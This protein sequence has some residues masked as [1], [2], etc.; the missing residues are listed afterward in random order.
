MDDISDAGGV[1]ARIGFKYQ[2]HVAASFVLDMLDDRRVVQVECE[3]SDDITRVL[4][5]DD[6]EIVEYIQVKTTDR[7]KK[8][9]S[10][11]LTARVTKDNPTSLVEKSLLADRHQPSAR[12]RIV[13]RRSVNA[14]LAALLDPIER[15]ETTGQISVLAAKLKAKYPKTF[16][17]NGH[18]L[19]YWAQNA[20]WDVRSG[21]EHI[22]SQNLQLLNRIAE[23]FG[24]NPTYSQAKK[25][26]SDL[27]LLVEAAAAATRRNKIKKVV[28]RTMI[29]DWWS[30][31]LAEVRATA[32]ASAKPYRIR[33]T[34]FFIEVH[35]V[36]YPLEKRQALGY[37]AQYERKV[38]RSL[39]LS[40]YLVSWLAELSLKASE[41]AEIDQLNLKQKLDAGLATIR[42]QRTLNSRELLGEALLHAILRHYFGSEPVACKLFHRSRLGDRITRNAHI[43]S[44]Q[45]GDQLW[46]GR[47]YFLEGDGERELLARIA[48]DLC[49]SLATE[50]LQEERQV[51]IQL[52]EPQHLT[53]RSLW[54]A[55]GPG[56]PIDRILEML[57]IPV[58]IAYDSAVLGV[59]H[60]DDYQQKLKSEIA[61]F[62]DRFVSSLPAQTVEVQVHVI[63]VPVENLCLLVSQFEKEIGLA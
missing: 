41:L 9:T 5:Q 47:T 23:E 31:R 63:F 48:D 19:A 10:T 3:T 29:V 22:E 27:L 8:W 20:L 61:K 24:A 34:S 33:G 56:A 62:G 4:H 40:Q 15:R 58:L 38:W 59:G 52:R 43:V 54:D 18:D 50:V 7:D 16:S 35:N 42:A 11:E 60:S 12:F 30:A 13:T 49:E 55:F 37:D 53:S 6:L 26:Y 51:I 57:C 36:P 28:T 2:D 25:I 21:L 1:A 45:Q 46:L 44:R 14:S 39:Q 17:S 32:A